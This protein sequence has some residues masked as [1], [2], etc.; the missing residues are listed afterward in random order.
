MKSILTSITLLITLIGVAYQG[1][2]F[3][4]RGLIH[5]EVNRNY[6]EVAG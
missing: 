3:F 4:K 6:I 1:F 2:R 5:K